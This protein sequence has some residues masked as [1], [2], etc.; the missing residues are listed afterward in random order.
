MS[1]TKTTTAFIDT[2]RRVKRPVVLIVDDEEPVRRTLEIMLK[3]SYETVLAKD[4]G[5][6]LD[7]V[8]SRPVDMVLLDINMPHTDGLKAIDMLRDADKE[9]A[10]LMLTA[11]DSAKTAAVALKKGACDYILKP[12]EEE[13][14]L[15]RLKLCAGELEHKYSVNFPKDAHRDDF[16]LSEIIT[17]SPR[18]QSVFEIIDKVSKTTASVFILGESGTG[19]ELV[20]RAIHSMSDRRGKPF[21]AINCGAVPSE[22]MESE[23]FG[24]E[25]GSFTGAHARKIGKFEYADEGTVFLDEISDLKP[26]LQTKLLRVLQEKTFERVGGVLPVRVDIR[27]I[28]ATNIDIKEAVRAGEFREDLFYRLKV[29]PIE[30]PPLRERKEDIPILARHF[31]KNHSKK[32]GKHGIRISPAAM[33]NLLKYQWPGNIR[34]LENF[35]ERLVVLSRDGSEITCKDLPHE[36]LCKTAVLGN[37]EPTDFREACMEFER[38]YILKVLNSTM[39]NRKET[40]ERL[41]IHR[42]TL[43]LKMR[44]L[45]LKKN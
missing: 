31:L 37:H 7:C 25:K 10:I 29:V 40:A 27:I 5:E 11:T 32:C 4:A 41:K 24:H 28:A 30:L 18:M 17:R 20:A 6:A 35:I 13:D 38:Q 19:K 34:E 33:H 21:V 8:R 15:Q 16:S 42:N 36:M 1:T 12:F 23:M 2:R 14:I 26:S 3:D 45:G 43:L 44:E 22:L 9:V 39:W